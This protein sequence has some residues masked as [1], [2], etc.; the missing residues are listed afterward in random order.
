MCACLTMSMLNN[1]HAKV[2]D[3]DQS[4]SQTHCYATIY[5]HIPD[6]FQ[7]VCANE[8]EV[9]RCIGVEIKTIDSVL[10]LKRPQLIKRTIELLELA[11]ANP[12]SSLVEH[13]LLGKIPIK[14]QKR[15]QLPLQVGYINVAILGW[16]DKTRH[17][18]GFIIK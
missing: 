6:G 3:F 8:V 11:E 13:P 17:I 14:I 9:D 10:T 2:I 5:L 15:R 1:W 12:R 16:L 18:N 7:F 4:Y